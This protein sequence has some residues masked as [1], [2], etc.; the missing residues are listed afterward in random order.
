M[1][2]NVKGLTLMPLLQIHLKSQLESV[3]SNKILNVTKNS[4][5]RNLVEICDD[6]NAFKDAKFYLLTL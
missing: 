1:G 4:C 2:E 6:F 3:K 5:F